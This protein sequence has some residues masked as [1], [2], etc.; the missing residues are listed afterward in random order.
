MF[1]L[2]YSIYELIRKISTN[3]KQSRIVHRAFLFL[4]DCLHAT[5]FILYFLSGKRFRAELKRIFSPK[6]C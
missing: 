6:S 1:T 3:S 2:P 4:L 5:N